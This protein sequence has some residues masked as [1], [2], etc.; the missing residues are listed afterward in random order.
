MADNK[1]ELVV[2]VDTNRANASIK[3]VNSSLSSMEAAAVKT[4]R[5]AAQS[6]D[7]MTVAMVKGATAGNLL[8]DAIKS[9]LNW[10][11]EF[12]VG[13]VMMAAENAKA[14]ASLKAL[15]NAHG[16]GAA[17]A[18]RQVAAIE[19]IGFE[20][21]EAAH[22]VQRLIVA[23]LE[24]SKAQGLAKLAKDAAAVQNITAGEAL[25]SIVMAIES[26]ASRGLR[27]L[28]LFVDFQKEAQIAQLQLGRA[29]TEAE[30]KQLR[31]N[32][33]MREGAKIQ[34]AHAAASQTVE[35]QLGA[36]RREFNNLREEIGAKFQDDFKALIGRLRGLVGWLL[37]NT[38]LLKKFGEV[39]LWVSGVLATYAL[40]DKIMALAKSVAALQLASIN[41]YA[42]LAV[43]VVGAGFAI[44]SQWKDTQ[45]QL[46]ARFDGMQ[47]KALRDDLLSGKTSIDALR[48]QGM[49][50]DQ[51]RE[52]VMGK[53]WL[54]GEQPFEYEGPKLTLK[55]AQ[56]PDLE[57]LK[58]AA[59]IRKRQLEVER[60]S[61][62]ALEDARRRGLTG[63]A[64]DVAEVQEQIRK[65]TTFVD[66]RGN[67]QRIALTRKSWENVIGELRVRL[68]NWQKE[69]QETNRK[70]LA[71]YLAAEEEAARRRLEIEAHLFS[72]RLAY[73]E[74]ISKCNLDHLEQ[75]LSIEEQRAGLTRDAQLRAVE[76]ADAQ[77]LEQKV[78]VEQRKAAI[79]IEYITRVHEIRMRLFDLETSRMVIEE[80]AQFQRLGYRADEIQ[81]RIAELTAQR[82][83]IRRFQQE[84]TDAAIQ[85]A[86]ETAA[87][88]QAQLIRDHNQR[89]F[90]SFKRQA[91]GVFDALLAKSQSIWSAIG[92][93]LK[94]ALLTAIKDVVSSRVAAMLMQ[95]FTGTRVWLAGGGASVGGALGRLGGVLGIG[96]VPVFGQGGGGPIPGGAAGGWG[97]PPFIPSN[98]GGGWS[99]LLGGWKDFLGFGGGVQYAPGKAVTWEAATM[100]QKLS[101]LGR[102]NAALLGGA[103]FALMGLQ[104]G[105]VSGLAMTTAGGAMIG[106]KYGGPLGAAIGAGIGAVAGLVRLFVKGAEEKAR[107]K[108]KATYGVDIREKNILAEIVNIAKQGFGGNLDMAIR[109]P[110]IRDL[111]ELYALST[112]QST[113]GLPATVRPVSLLQQGGSL[114]QSSSGGL[115]LDR[116]G[117]GAPPSATGPT[118]I[119]ITVPGAKE[120]FEKE[121]VRVVVEN[122]RAVQSAAMTAT[123]ASAGRREMTG[124]QLSPGLILS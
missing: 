74:E 18:A 100:G 77:T 35:G 89:I 83:E 52:L 99:G 79:E 27:T 49:T 34:G 28:G 105:G 32:A 97:T 26:G 92:N 70:N 104:R 118:V 107:E 116:I 114:F 111:V 43:G 50:D 95:L 40:A 14:E 46:Q 120:F 108:I 68:A 53:R 22:T 96:A 60:E 94:T 90:D 62:R 80:E 1:L 30:E 115:T 63:F 8:A 2:E 42:L 44:Y 76:A 4:A 123:K 84:A 117:G 24:L 71:E 41:P 51:I 75:M 15:A 82:D 21:T 98:S 69:V 9:A 3:S 91:E 106:F 17:A 47:R 5:G 88:R 87:I 124:L 112:G 45:D 101:A 56:E 31:Y 66:E 10:A 16:V 85:G 73:N 109:S 64:R 59:D 113:S 12:T 33:V 57:A 122:P 29:L 67:E 19:E 7:G 65:W 61:A 55:T 13:S 11:K 54:P 110:Q 58:R 25:E 102:S 86:R 121:T 23:D 37:E 20:Y 6:I 72:Q 119:N 38:D 78:A 93:S 36:L 103:T 39:A 48:K 81:A